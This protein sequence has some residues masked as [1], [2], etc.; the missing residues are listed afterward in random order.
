MGYS[1]VENEWTDEDWDR[2]ESTVV[3]INDNIITMINTNK[4]E[5]GSKG[6][7]PII[8]VN[9]QSQKII[10]NLREN[11]GASSGNGG[12]GSNGGESSSDGF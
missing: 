6:S 11:I 7:V 8:A 5:Y 2:L 12:G 3:I 10:Q 4:N 9:E 1:K